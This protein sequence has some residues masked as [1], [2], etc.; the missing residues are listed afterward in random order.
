MSE[1]G[2]PGLE[3][4]FAE[5]NGVRLHY[6]RAGA[7]PLIVFIHGLPQ[8]WYIYR[9]QLAEFSR[10]HLAVA[11]DIRGFNQSGKPERLTDYGV[12]A[13]ME[14]VAALVEHLGYDR[15]V[16]VGHDIG[17]AIG[18][19]FV[20]HH[21]EMV[22]GIVTIGGA[23]PALFDRS[24]SE[25]PEQQRASRHW[26]SLRR[27]NSEAFY[28]AN[29]FAPFRT[30]FDGMDFFT[31]DDRAAYVR[32]WREP[33]AIEGILAWARREGW[34][35]PEG[36]TPPKGNYVPEV[37]PLTTDVPALAIYGD[38]DRYIR[39]V[40]YEGLDDYATNLT[41]HRVAGA[42]HWICEEVPQVVN[43]HIREFVT[44]L[45]SGAVVPAGAETRS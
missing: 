24:L 1:A 33:G 12:L 3:H 43:T 14:D 25:D 7:G 5:F 27:P 34:G 22:E 19:S 9:H 32:S 45:R 2:V 21:P 23:H 28:R 39:P 40:C 26:L 8:F 10:D 15:V 16:V 11:V 17:V 18:W 31:E 6:V 13:S 42:S 37:S 29:D 36:S 38:A 20:L 30:I 35:P 4:E 44:D 41:V